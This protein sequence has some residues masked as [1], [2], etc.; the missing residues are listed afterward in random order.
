GIRSRP[1]LGG[2]DIRCLENGS[3]GARI[4]RK[5][6]RLGSAAEEDSKAHA[7]GDSLQERLAGIEATAC[8]IESPLMGVQQADVAQK[9]SF[10]AS[11]PDRARDGQRRLEVIR[12]LVEASEAVVGHPEVA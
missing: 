1:D 10:S 9:L 12:G 3:R 7:V 11:I 6:L 5:M 2:D 4:S 8:I